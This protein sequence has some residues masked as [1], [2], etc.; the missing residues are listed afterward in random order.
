MA[1][2]II[3]RPRQSGKTH[4]LVEWV[5]A[6]P[7]RLIVTPTHR[8][9]LRLQLSYGLKRQ[10]VVSFADFL[11]HPPSHHV[12]VA[13]D[14]LDLAKKGKLKLKSAKDLYNEL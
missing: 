2:R 7:D 6:E 9:A 8:E 1:L 3:S 10:Q 13:V 12:D 14:N 4:G 5:K 11:K